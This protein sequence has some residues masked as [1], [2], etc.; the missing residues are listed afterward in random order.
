MRIYYNEDY[1]YYVGSQDEEKLAIKVEWSSSCSYQ[2]DQT[3]LSQGK[4]F[5]LSFEFTVNSSYISMQLSWVILIYL[6]QAYLL[7]IF[8]LYRDA[9]NPRVRSPSSSKV[10]FMIVKCHDKMKSYYITWLILL[11]NMLMFPMY[12]YL[13]LILEPL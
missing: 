2:S 1:Y 11:I 7:F 10:F 13:I 3:S 5:N 6:N 4:W 9:L 8:E 12:W